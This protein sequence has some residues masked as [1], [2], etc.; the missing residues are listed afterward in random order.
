MSDTDYI[1]EF[2]DIKNFDPSLIINPDSIYFIPMTTQV[3]TRYRQV[4]LKF[5][6]LMGRDY[7]T[8]VSGPV[9][10][11]SF[12]IRVNNERMSLNL[13]GDYPLFSFDAQLTFKNADILSYSRAICNETSTDIYDFTPT[14]SFTLSDIKYIILKDDTFISSLNALGLYPTFDENPPCLSLPAV[15][16]LNMVA[17]K[18]WK[19][20]TRVTDMSYYMS[21]FDAVDYWKTG[22]KLN[23]IVGHIDSI[24]GFTNWVNSFATIC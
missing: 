16:L 1:Q 19:L 20:R 8:S 15:E 6:T 18:E 14:S 17:R 4:N 9:D 23:Y 13:T 11:N 2:I 10:A 7:I 5:K 12:V 24:N 3:S 21:I 22:N